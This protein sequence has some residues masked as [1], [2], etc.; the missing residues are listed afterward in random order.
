MNAF[1]HIPEA[2]L[3]QEPQFFVEQRDTD[4]ASE[5]ARV[6]RFRNALRMKLPDARWR[7]VPNAHDYG[8]KAR[9]QALAEGAVWGAEDGNLFWRGRVACLEWKNGKEMPKR[10]QVEWLN[11]L[12]ANGFT[13]AV[14]RTTEGAFEFLRKQGWPV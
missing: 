14:V 5:K 4:S 6:V 7:A 3:E 9:A 13:V 10:H 1:A 2:D 8:P 12:H 11:W